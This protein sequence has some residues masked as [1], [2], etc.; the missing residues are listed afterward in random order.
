LGLTASNA[1]DELI[2]VIHLGLWVTI[3]FSIEG[4]VLSKGA[5]P[6]R[7]GPAH[8]ICRVV[9]AALMQPWLPLLAIPHAAGLP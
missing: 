2:V 4:G 7:G 6:P 3:L 5:A 9:G 1:P 8:E